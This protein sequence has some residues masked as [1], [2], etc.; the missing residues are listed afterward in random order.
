MSPLIFQDA[1]TENP[2]FQSPDVYEE[3]PFAILCLQTSGRKEWET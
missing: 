3:P 1:F 2:H